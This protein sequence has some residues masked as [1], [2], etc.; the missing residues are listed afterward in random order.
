M[1]IEPADAAVGAAEIP[2]TAAEIL[3]V[4]VPDVVSDD[5]ADGSDPVAAGLT[6]RRGLLAKI[7]TRRS[8]RSD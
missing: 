3:I 4:L 8:Q 7:W 5:T 2:S 1:T 6:S